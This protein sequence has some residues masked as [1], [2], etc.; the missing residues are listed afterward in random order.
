VKTRFQITAFILFSFLTASALLAQD[1]YNLAYKYEKGKTY[2]SRITMGMDI[3]QSMSGQDFNIRMDSK[4]KLRMEITDVTSDKFEIISSIDSM[5]SKTSNPMGG[6]DIINNGE[7]MVGKKTKIV[8]DKFGKVIRKTEIDQLA[9]TLN[10]NYS[11]SSEGMFR[12]TEKQVKIGDTWAINDTNKMSMG[13]TGGMN[14]ITL[15]D[16]KLEGKETYNGKEC[17]KISFVQKITMNGELSQAGMALGIDETGYSKGIIYYDIA[18]GL[19]LSNDSAMEMNGT[20]SMGEQGMP[21]SQKVKTSIVLL[22]N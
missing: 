21:M 2:F 5:Y 6:D 19:I 14:I 18:K 15:C 4:S 11:G 9:K 22:D 12:L 7:G 8:Y 1:T 20:V 16:C 3:A 13:E 17:L 10:M